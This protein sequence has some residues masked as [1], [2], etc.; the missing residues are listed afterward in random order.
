MN[1]LAIHGGS[2]SIKSPL[3]KRVAFGKNEVSALLEAVEFYS[4][5]DNDPGYF[6]PYEQQYC[7]QFSEY[8]GGGYTTAVAT[9]TG[10]LFVAI[11]ALEL[12]KNSHIIMSPLTDPGSFSAITLNGFK[13]SLADTEA[14][15]LNTS[16]QQIEK[17]ITPNTT[18]ILLVHCA[19]IAAD[20]ETISDNARARGIKLIEDC[21]Q[22]PGAVYNDKKLGTFGDVAA[23]S[24]MYRKSLASGGS[25]GLIYTKNKKLYNK[26][27]AYADRGKDFSN[28][29]FQERNAEEY[30]FPALNWNTNELSCA[31]GIAS[32]KRLDKTIKDRATF[33]KDMIRKINTL[34]LCKAPEFIQ[35]TSPFF[36]TVYLTENSPISK[37]VYCEALIAEGIELN[38]QYRFVV[39]QWQWAKP[40]FS[41]HYNTPNAVLSRDRSFNIYLN[42]NYT[43]DTCE[44]LYQAMLKVESHFL[45]IKE[46]V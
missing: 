24:T 17:V 19:G 46:Q 13:V 14:D 42:E 27:L 20:I 12:P 40:Y 1:K 37:A 8:M 39:S 3:P 41:E 36:L 26:C 21:S 45:A 11:A 35:G 31:I 34:K 16:W 7:K 5:D 44:A 22:S 43:S 10:S 30:M 25:G 33:C 32:L 9:G 4:N 28:E 15:S 6:G 29:S 23:L 18:A 2:P 38:P